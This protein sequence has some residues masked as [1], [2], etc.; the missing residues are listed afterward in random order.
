MLN[1]TKQYASQH[2]VTA[3]ISS[4]LNLVVRLTHYIFCMCT[5]AMVLMMWL[6]IDFT[7]G[8]VNA[9]IINRQWPSGIGVNEFM[10]FH[11]SDMSK[12]MHLNKSSS[13]I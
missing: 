8:V 11:D 3:S 2:Y 10:T 5:N 4:K 6:F 7:D 1:G 9:R 13:V 12:I